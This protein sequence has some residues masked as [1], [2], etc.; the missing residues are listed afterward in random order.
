MSYWY[1]FDNRGG[2]SITPPAPQ[3]FQAIWSEDSPDRTGYWIISEDGTVLKLEEPKG[4]NNEGFEEELQA[5][6]DDLEVVGCKVN[7]KSAFCGEETIY[8]EVGT[9]TIV[10]NKVVC[11]YMGCLAE[12]LYKSEVK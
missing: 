6:C 10:Q 5:I 8:S 1:D 11:W 12:L 2:F 4:G 3:Q 7:G 9:V